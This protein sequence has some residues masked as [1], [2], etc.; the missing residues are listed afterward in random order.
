VLK[1]NR[2]GANPFA[3]PFQR[4]HVLIHSI[5]CPKTFRVILHVTAPLIITFR[6][7][8]EASLVIGIV[9][10]Y[11]HRLDL[12]KHDIYVWSGVAMGV[13]CSIVIAILFTLLF[14]GFSGQAEELYEGVIMLVASGLVCW[15]VVWMWRQRKQIRGDIEGKVDRHLT[16]NWPLGIFFLVFLSVLR[17]GTETVIFLHAAF[18][19]AKSALLSFG[20]A[21]LGFGGAIGLSYL[22]FRGMKLFNIK[23]FFT[24]TS[25]LLL[26]FAASL[27][28][29]GV[30]E[31]VEAFGV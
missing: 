6:E 8:L 15:M 28:V 13:V 4:G 25:V 30:E 23:H 3:P 1:Q 31:L 5:D 12:N 20:G 27:F 19:Q 2:G 26:M 14:G 10:A 17:E 11:L 21:V 7:S 29:E 18:A 22:F 9:L 24:V 16:K